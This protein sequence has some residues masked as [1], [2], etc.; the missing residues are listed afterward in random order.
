VQG[1]PGHF[2]ATHVLGV[3]IVRLEADYSAGGTPVARVTIAATVARYGDRRAL[4]AMTA[5]AETAAPANTLTAVVAALDEAFGKAA[6]EVV[7][8]TGDALAADL[9]GQP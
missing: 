9:A 8:R 3:E 5:S 1:D 4:M 2:R 6:A 7:T